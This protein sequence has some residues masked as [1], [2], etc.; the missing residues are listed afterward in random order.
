MKTMMAVTETTGTIP[1]QTSHSQLSENRY[2]Y[3]EGLGYNDWGQL[4]GAT[5]YYSPW[6]TESDGFFCAGHF[7]IPAF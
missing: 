6:G 4:P 1:F 3:E 5:E 7:G 2:T